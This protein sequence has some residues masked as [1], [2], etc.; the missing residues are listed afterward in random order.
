MKKLLVRITAPYFVA[1]VEVRKIFE[2]RMGDRD[3]YDNICAPI[4]KYM[5]KWSPLRIRDYCRKKSWR[6]EPL[7]KK[8]KKNF[9]S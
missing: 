9:T 7:L 3:E 4:V 6:Y 5:K 1:G 8:N 2:G